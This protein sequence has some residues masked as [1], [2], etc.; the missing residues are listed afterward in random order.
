MF[1]MLSLPAFAGELYT[2]HKAA[3][4][5]QAPHA[6]FTLAGEKAPV[7]MK[8]FRGKV[9][10]VNFWATWCAPCLEELPTLAALQNNY[11]KND[12]V[13]LA[14]SVDA[15]PFA[16]VKRF[17]RNKRIDTP[18]LAHDKTGDFY[19]PLSASGLPL[20]YVID[21]KGNV[22]YRYEGATDW[23]DDEHAEIIKEVL[24]HGR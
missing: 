1:A 9:V 21:R 3:R 22:A 11:A 4:E 8:H 5:K 13:V 24:A 15:K 18:L 2:W 12:V 16:V 7:T 19:Q 10:V 14:M 6:S 20:T 23:T 17:L